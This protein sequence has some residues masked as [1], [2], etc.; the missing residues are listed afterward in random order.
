MGIHSLQH[1]TPRPTTTLA[2]SPAIVCTAK[3]HVGLKDGLRVGRR[4]DSTPHVKRRRRD[5]KSPTVK[6]L[7]CLGEPLQVKQF[8]CIS[9][10]SGKQFDRLGELTNGHSPSR[11]HVL[12]HHDGSG[13][14]RI[15]LH[16]GQLHDLPVLHCMTNLPADGIAG[17]SC[18]PRVP[19]PLEHVQG[20]L[21][22]CML[23]VRGGCI[24]LLGFDIHVLLP[25][26][27][28]T[29]ADKEDVAALEGDVTLLSNLENVSQLDGVEGK[30]CV[31]NALLLCPGGIVDE[32][33]TA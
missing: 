7:A 32:D 18:K 33:S 8:T 24:R 16:V 6:L 11:E 23:R 26:F 28:D 9:S 2:A 17:Y 29:D 25:L 3:F 30:G 31:F 14:R 4:R 13:R 15:H 20:S 19:H 21:N 1:A 10:A 5:K 27:D 12:V 22:A